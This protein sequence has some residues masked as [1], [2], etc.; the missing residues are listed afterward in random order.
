MKTALQNRQILDKLRDELIY[1]LAIAAISIIALKI[2]FF[3]EAWI[4]TLRL[5]LSFVWVFILP[6]LSIMFYWEDKLRFTERLIIGVGISSAIIGIA[7]YYIGLIG[8]NI[9]Y[10]VILLPLLCLA[11]G[12][13]IA[14]KTKFSHRQPG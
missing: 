2:V 12:A 7:S 1:V 9:K 3:K 8:L 11:A 5:V 14:F 6:G 10:H 4:V 13:F